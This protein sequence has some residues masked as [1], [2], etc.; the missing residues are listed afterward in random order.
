[1]FYLTIRIYHETRVAGFVL[2]WMRVAFACFG[3]SERFS[4]SLACI[5][6]II[7]WRFGNKGSIPDAH[8]LSHG[9]FMYVGE[10]KYLRREE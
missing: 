1:V 3:Y 7:F 5:G 6:C 9:L 8:M 10:K 2:L 4:L